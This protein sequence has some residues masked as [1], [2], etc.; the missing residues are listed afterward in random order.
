VCVVVGGGGGVLL[1][2]LLH[3]VFFVCCCVFS[4]KSTPQQLL[5]KRV[6][7]C[8]CCCIL[9]FLCVV[10]FSREKVLPSS[11]SKNVFSAQSVQR[12]KRSVFLFFSRETA[13]ERDRSSWHH[14]AV[15]AAVLLYRTVRPTAGNVIVYMVGKAQPAVVGDKKTPVSL[16]AGGRF[17]FTG[18]VQSN[19]TV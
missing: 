3:F 15:S 7:C 8:C 19:Y 12:I 2:L 18:R 6:F 10:V 16:A 4:R 13:A 14:F 9:S 1:L 5:K 11:C 17:I